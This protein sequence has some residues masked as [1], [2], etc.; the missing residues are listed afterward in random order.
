M[1]RG[2]AAIAS[3]SCTHFGGGR[4]T[5]AGTVAGASGPAGSEA[6]AT[7]SNSIGDGSC[8]GCTSATPSATQQPVLTS[9]SLPTG[10][11]PRG[12]G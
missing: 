6:L 10:A 1:A 9:H 8:S 4:G 3:A 12:R 7:A 11:R 5:L 2:G